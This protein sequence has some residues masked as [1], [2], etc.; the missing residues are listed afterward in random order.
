MTGDQFASF[1][2]D[3]IAADVKSTAMFG[4]N[5]LH[6]ADRATLLALQHGGQG[7]RLAELST[8]SHVPGS[9]PYFNPFA[10]PKPAGAV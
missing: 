3:T 1:L 10:T 5:F 6:I 8:A 9:Q 7:G 2:S 4:N